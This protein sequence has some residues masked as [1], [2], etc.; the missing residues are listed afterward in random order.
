MTV[1]N[2]VTNDF[3]VGCGSCKL[4]LKDKVK[5]TF[6]DDGFYNASI[7][8]N[9]SKSELLQANALCPFSSESP[10]EDELGKL[11]YKDQKHSKKIGYYSNVYAGSINN[12]SDKLKSSSGGLTSWFAEKLI[13]NDEV[14]AVIHVG[15]GNGMF[16]YKVSKTIEELKSKS[17]RKSRYYPVTFE[18]LI[19]YIISTDDRL[20]FIGIPCFVKSIRL[21]QKEHGLTN[22]KYVFSLVCGHMK[23]AA[24]AE[25][26]AWQLGVKPSDLEDFDFRVK[27]K[28]SKASNYFVEAKSKN[29]TVVTQKNSNLYG[30]DWGQGFFKHKACDF[31]DDLAGELADITFG[32]AWLPKYTDDYLGTNIIIFRSEKLEGYFEEYRQEVSFEKLDISD[33]VTSQAANYRHRRDGLITRIENEKNWIPPKRL[34]LSIEV[35]NA[36]RK[37]L[38]LFRRYL[39]ERSVFYFK[40]AKKFGSFQLFKFLMY[41]LLLRYE[42]LIHGRNKFVKIKYKETKAVMKRA[43]KRLLVRLHIMKNNNQEKK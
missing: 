23:S 27:D 1:Q 29:G 28:S 42:M 16:N 7:S 31:C 14:D 26:L 24:F 20:L 3:C 21:V 5:I 19:E 43:L 41:P 6:T 34:Y 8:S 36:R 13:E 38:Y 35:P 9:A 39:S 33:Y 32:D 30:A 18:H 11:L 15:H 25:S 2:V 37:K 40:I 22:L 17:N 12:A 4:A 10:N